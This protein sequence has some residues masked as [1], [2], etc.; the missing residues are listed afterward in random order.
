MKWL[1]WILLVMLL[2]GCNSYRKLSP[3]IEPSSESWT[4]SKVGGGRPA[5]IDTAMV[6]RNA[7]VKSKL[8]FIDFAGW[9]IIEERGESTELRMV[10]K[11]HPWMENTFGIGKMYMG[12]FVEIAI[13]VDDQCL[14]SPIQVMRGNPIFLYEVRTDCFEYDSLN[15]V[16]F[17]E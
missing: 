9:K 5:E 1:L 7:Y 6:R 17:D 3:G 10:K 4:A 13:R 8:P 14:Y 2:I 16:F 12:T 15:K 11:K